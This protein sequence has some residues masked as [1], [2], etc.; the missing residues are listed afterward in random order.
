MIA[1]DP[2][3][4]ANSRG[5]ADDEN[6]SKNSVQFMITNKMR[7]I[8]HN[9][10]GYLQEEIDDMEPQIGAVLIERNLSRP[11]NGMPSSWR[12]ANSVSK[13]ANGPNL[14]SKFAGSIYGSLVTV[15]NIILSISP[16]VP[17]LVL[18]GSAVYFNRGILLG[19]HRTVLES[20][21]AKKADSS[22]KPKLKLASTA[23]DKSINLDMT[24]FG[25]VQ[26]QSPLQKANLSLNIFRRKTI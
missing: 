4:E 16:V 7:K 2:R 20:Y 6:N 19:M 17:A 5:A 25:K 26:K 13:E 8:L 23:L 14:F 22:D 15:K 12:R 10:L 21:R 11:Y 3:Q 9:D 18:G 24:S 1:N